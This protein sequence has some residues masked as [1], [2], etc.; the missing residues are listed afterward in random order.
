MELKFDADG[1]L[2]A[3]DWRLVRQSDISVLERPKLAEM[4]ESLR[5]RRLNK[6]MATGKRVG[7]NEQ[8][9]CGSGKKFKKCCIE[10]SA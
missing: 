1:R 6:G 3:A 8:C 9:P 10:R 7:R 4:A 2:N 5:E